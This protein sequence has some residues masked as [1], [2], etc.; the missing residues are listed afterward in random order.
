MPIQMST[1]DHSGNRAPGRDSPA[2]TGTLTFDFPPL[3]APPGF[4]SS[5][6]SSFLAHPGALG[7]FGFL[8][9]AVVGAAGGGT[10]PAG[11]P[12]YIIPG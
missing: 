4:P 6:V 9:G 7:F 3:M 10:G 1:T 11:Y 8:G 5:V 2:K 12:G